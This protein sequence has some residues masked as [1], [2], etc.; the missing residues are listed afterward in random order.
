MLK[1]HFIVLAVTIGGLIALQPG[2][3]AE[4]SRRLGSPFVAAFI[5]VTVAFIL[6]LG[7]MLV[8]RPTIHW[9]AI[10]TMPWY[11]WLGGVIGVVFVIGTLWLAPVLGAGTLFAAMVAGQMITATAVD[12]AGLTGY[13]SQGFDPMRLVAIALVVGGVAIFY[14]TA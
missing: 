6:C 12:W 4:V 5:S 11:V 10:G 1:L 13:Q 3:N 8:T 7:Y 9:S 2:L 14:R